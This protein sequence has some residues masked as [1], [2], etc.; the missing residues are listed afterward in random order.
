ML[1]GVDD[2]LRSL[3]A[4]EAACG[5]ILVFCKSPLNVGRDSRIQR[6]VFALKQ[7][8]EVPHSLFLLHISP[9][10]ICADGEPE[11]DPKPVLRLYRIQRSHAEEQYEYREIRPEF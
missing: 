8:N 10:E 5:A 6:F 3:C 4:G 1:F 2:T 7:I 9:E 11:D